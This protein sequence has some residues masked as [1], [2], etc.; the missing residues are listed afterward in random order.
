MRVVIY[1]FYIMF[2][3]A[4]HNSQVAGFQAAHALHVQNQ[5]SIDNFMSSLLSIK[6]SLDAT[7]FKNLVEKFRPIQRSIPTYV[8]IPCNWWPEGLIFADQDSDEKVMCKCKSGICD[9]NCQNRNM[10]YL[11]SPN[12]C[13]FAANG[14][15]CGNTGDC[16][17]PLKLQVV[18]TANGDR[19]L[20]TTANI[21]KGVLLAE[22]V[23]QGKLGLLTGPYMLQIPKDN[24]Y[25]PID[26]TLDAKELGGIARFANH[27]CTPNCYLELFKG[28]NGEPHIFLVSLINIIVDELPIELTHQ[29]AER[30]F[31]VCWCIKCAAASSV[32]L[33]SAAVSADT[34]DTAT[35]FNLLHSAEAMTVVSEP[36]ESAS[37]PQADSSSAP[38]AHSSSDP[39]TDSSGPKHDETMTVVSEPQESASSPQADSSSAPEA[40]S[41]SAPH[42]NSIS[43]PR[44]DSSL[45]PQ[46]G[47]GECSENSA[48]GYPE[49]NKFNILFFIFFCSSGGYYATRHTE[50]LERIGFPF[51][52]GIQ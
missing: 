1:L 13:Q 7:T 25:P 11:C 6:N 46:A 5:N 50:E 38:E 44:A 40:H 29:Y 48:V 19:K 45:A 39:Q 26:I 36:Q 20:E 32:P 14:N 4:A 37:S 49:F 30:D 8:D 9:E 12:N 41:S 28:Q 47:S 27:S 42:A 52:W 43:A 10:K 33:S 17:D 2:C 21:R 18:W 16:V 31:T 51:C 3:L 34:A 24:F 23:G 22:Y 35:A 15:S